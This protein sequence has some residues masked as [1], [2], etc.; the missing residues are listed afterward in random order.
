M[1]YPLYEAPLA[2]PPEQ[3]VIFFHGYGANGEDLLS[4]STHFEQTLQKA[5]FIG[6]NAFTQIPDYPVDYQWFDL[7]N[8]DPHLMEINCAGVKDRGVALIQELQR[9]WDIPPEKTLLIGFSQGTM[10]ALYCALAEANL[11]GAVIGYSGGVYINPESIQAKPEDLDI[12]LIHGEEDS[13]VP[14]SASQDTHAFLKHQGFTPEIHLRP[15]LE[16]SIDLEGLQIAR[17][18][19]KKHPNISRTLEDS[20][21]KK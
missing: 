17:N 3:L 7:A 8:M 1:R 6:P 19:I 20:C 18:F 12:L 21:A 9:E 5:I 10:M 14:A 16:H 13:V 11:C 15:G 2:H 4:L